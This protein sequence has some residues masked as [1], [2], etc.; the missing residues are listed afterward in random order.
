ML[1][2]NWWFLGELLISLLVT[3]VAIWGFRHSS[4]FPQRLMRVGVQL[5]C[6][7]AGLLGSLGVLLLVA[8]LGCESRSVPIYSPSGELAARIE[9]VDEGATG[10]STTVELYSAHG[11]RRSVIFWAGEW[12]SVEPADIHWASDSELTIS[13]HGQ[14]HNCASTAAVRVNCRYE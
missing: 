8:A 6:L 1:L 12:K 13:F 14:A 4:R 3:G 9:W 11:F 10:G 7:P 5:V 2:V